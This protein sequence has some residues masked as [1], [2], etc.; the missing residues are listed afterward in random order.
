MPP[1]AKWRAAARNG[2]PSRCGGQ[3]FP[4][5]RD[6]ATPKKITI[7]F[8]RGDCYRLIPVNGVWG[9]VT[10]RG[11]IK[12]DLFHESA[13]VPEM[14]THE[15]TPQGTLGR[16]VKRT[17]STS[18][19]RTVFAGMV[20]T[21]E[22]AESIGSWLVERAREARKRHEARTQEK[23]DDDSERDTPTTH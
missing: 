13:S 1:V 18:V 4:G 16:E 15:V 22:Q 3:G 23:G 9:G 7:S 20:L 12:A 17:P 5:L 21:P 10:P 11:D 6:V 19:E 2:H 14:I 8:R